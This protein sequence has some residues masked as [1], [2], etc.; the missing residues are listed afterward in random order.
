VTY[1]LV[2]GTMLP[3]DVAD[4]NTQIGSLIR[5][6]NGRDT[7]DAASDWVFTTTLTRGTANVHTAA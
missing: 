2:E 1:N 4:S 3:E 6:P 5:N 7:N